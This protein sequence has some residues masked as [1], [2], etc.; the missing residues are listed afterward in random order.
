MW[1]T[2]NGISIS[3]N[4]ERVIVNHEEQ[5]Q[6]VVLAALNGKLSHLQALHKLVYNFQAH[7][8]SSQ[9]LFSIFAANTACN[10]KKR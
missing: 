4:V 8:H 1:M 10:I 3:E 2:R 9:F 5:G 6:T 7:R